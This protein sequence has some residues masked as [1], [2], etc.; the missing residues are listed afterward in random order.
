[1]LIP[2][3]SRNPLF[4]SSQLA[5]WCLK[6]RC[7]IFIVLYAQKS[8]S[9]SLCFLVQYVYISHLLKPTS[10]TSEITTIYR[11]FWPSNHYI[12][13]LSSMY[14]TRVTF[15]LEMTEDFYLGDD[16]LFIILLLWITLF[17]P[18]RHSFSCHFRLLSR[19]L[20]EDPFLALPPYRS[21]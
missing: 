7:A 5:I 1:M 15:I 3:W 12:L 6:C 21:L 8:A 14:L 13:W 4:C 20:G 2:T 11:C 17:G 19:G 18:L 9:Y 10:F 16:A